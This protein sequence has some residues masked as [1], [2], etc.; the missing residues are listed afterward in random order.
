MTYA[1]AVLIPILTLALTLALTV[2]VS[3]IRENRR[4]EAELNRIND[5]WAAYYAKGGK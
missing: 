4:H 1:L 3:G 2:G 5:E